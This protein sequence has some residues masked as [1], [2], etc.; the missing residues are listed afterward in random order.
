VNLT[1]IV[2]A[3]MLM[4]PLAFLPAPSA[5]QRPATITMPVADHHAHLFS[6]ADA[7]RDSDT[8]LPAV[9]LPPELARLMDERAQRWNRQGP[10]GELYTE[11]SWVLGDDGGR[12]IWLQ[13]RQAG[14]ESL[15]QRFARAYRVTPVA[16][17]ID[18]ATGYIAGYFTR[19]LDDGTTRYFG[20]VLMSL[21]KEADG[22]WRIA[23]ETPTFPG[24]T[25]GRSYT[26]DQLVASLDA[27]GVRRAAVLSVAYWYG[28]PRSPRAANEHEQVRAENDWVADQVARFPDRLVGFCSFNP[29]RDYALQELE[30]CASVPGIR[31]IKLHFGNSR[32][33]LLEPADAERVRSVFA[34]ANARR[35]AIVAH[36][37]TGPEYETA[38]A[39]H[40]RVVLETLLPAAPDVPVQIAHFAGGGPGYTD[41]ALAVLA[42]AVAAGA[43]QTR[44]LYFDIATVADEQ[45]D[46]VLKTFAARIRQVGVQRVLFGNDASSQARWE[47]WMRFRATVPLTDAE[48][49]TIAG[50]VA[51]YFR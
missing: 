48:F 28:S 18:G 32:V 15:S 35:L 14:S 1:A 34:A 29:L 50:N 19:P 11:D 13:G 36:L 21:R 17:R 38:G 10:L 23:A 46:E 30:R 6:P 5:A 16:Y 37:W 9:A 20:Q 25:T 3:A 49:D 4:V 42:E 2:G 45:P 22:V 44:N 33:N 47:Q 27:A 43:P 12:P 51:P 7:A 31:G 24:L 8:P 39:R 40:A 26:A 41:P